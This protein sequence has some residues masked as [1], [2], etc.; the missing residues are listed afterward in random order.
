MS[1]LVIETRHNEYEIS[2]DP[3]RVDID[4][5][6]DFLSNQGYWSLGRSRELVETS[7]RNSGLICAAYGAEG[8]VVG[9]A[10][11]VTDFGTFAYLCDDFLLPEQRGTGLGVAIVTTIVEHPDVAMLKRQMLATRDA[12]ELY[13]KLG[14][15]PLD[16]P[17]K[18]M[19]RRNPVSPR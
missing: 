1:P 17:V 9:T 8:D 6:H 13:R 14:F 10:R 3:A 5:V 15:E 19:E 11:M 7:I 18:W 2:T 4:Q 12:H 16:E